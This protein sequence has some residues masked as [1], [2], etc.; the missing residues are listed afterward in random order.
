M[1]ELLRTKQGKTERTLVAKSAVKQFCETSTIHGISSIYSAS[2]TSLKILWVGIFL[3]VNSLMIWQVS[4]LVVKVYKRDVLITARKVSHDHLEFPCVSVSNAGPYSK[5]K[6]MDIASTGSDSIE[7]MKKIISNLSAPHVFGLSND[8]QYSCKFGGNTCQAERAIFP[9]IGTYLLFNREMRW[10]QMKPG[11]ENGL[12]LVLNINESNY[13]NVLKH[14][15][16][17]L[18]YIGELFVTYS[19]LHNKG[20]AVA[21]GTLTKINMQV[22]KTTR[23]PHPYPDNCVA[24]TDVRELQGFH[25]RFTLSRIYS[26]EFCKFL[27]MLRAQMTSCGVV[28]PQYKLLIDLVVIVEK[29][30]VSYTISG[31]RSKIESTMN[32]LKRVANKKIE[33]NCRRPCISRKFDFTVS[34]LRWPSVEEAEERLETLKKSSSQARN[35]TLEDIY[36]NLLKVQ[37]F[38]SDFDIDEVGQKPAYTWEMLPSDLGGLIGLY[39]GASVYSGLEVFSFLFS[40]LYYLYHTTLKRPPARSK[41]LQT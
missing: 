22:T 23:L 41:E 27:A 28:D 31:D 26:L 12:E 33:S 32:C 16:G 18:I 35:W 5:S 6:L 40:L 8:L 9:L 24:N 25:S 15:Y 3:A 20:I 37:I 1:E 38:F 29:S 13:A 19:H 11:P 34:H 10:K 4:E 2:N 39:I 17:V 14:G 21:P 7:S 36:R 30:N